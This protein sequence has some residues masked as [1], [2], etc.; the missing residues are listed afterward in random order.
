MLDVNSILSD[1]WSHNYLAAVL[2]VALYLR[3]LFSSKSAFPLTLKPAFQAVFSAVAVGIVAAVTMAQ[4]SGSTVQAD[5]VAGLAGAVAGGF[6]DGLLAAIFGSAANAPAW[7]KLL[8]GILDNVASTGGG[9]GGAAV[10]NSVS[11][12][13]TPAAPAEK[14]HQRVWGAW[15]GAT[16]L[17]ALML[18]GVAT[19]TSSCNG[20]TPNSVLSTLDA[21]TSAVLAGIQRGETAEQIEI[22]VAKILNPDAGA[23][24]AAVV[25]AVNDAITILVDLGVIPPHLIPQAKAV[26]HTELAKLVSMQVAK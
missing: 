20:V 24:D 8:V 4:K 25:I 14:P 12:P 22:D 11:S 16:A 6:L 13:A 5:V 19:A 18:A 23:I 1:L 9:S 10:T 21:V 26:Q 7:A 17:T 3:T 15:A 2:V